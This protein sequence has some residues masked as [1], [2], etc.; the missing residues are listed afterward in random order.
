MVKKTQILKPDT[1]LKNYWNDNGQFADFFNAVLFG[2]EQVISP[3]DLEDVDTQESTILE[4]KEYAESIQAARDNI[5]ICKR[6]LTHGVEL[7]MLGIESQ[8]HIH[9][10]MPMRVMG[11]DYGAYKKQYDSNAVQYQTRKGL[12]ENEFLSRMKK[13]DKFIPVVTVVVYYGSIPWDGATTLYGMLNVSDRMKPFVNDYKML[14]VEARKN[15]LLFHNMNNV[16]F[17]NMIKIVL[18]SS[19]EKNAAKKKVIEYAAEHNV[20]KTVVMTV[21]GAAKC[22][23]DYHALSKKGEVGMYSLFDEI[24]KD[25][26]AE[27]KTEGRAEG[28]I[29]TG[30]DFG[31]SEEEILQ[32]LQDKLHLSLQKAQEYFELFGKQTV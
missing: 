24:A 9:Y 18:D 26:K 6:S 17:F 7:V 3:D 30:L 5:K 20:D 11:Y 32:R 31:L 27:G 19:M 10:A 4:H 25:C 14:L 12:D 1:V 29:E 16:D 22:A 8:E 13:T 28:I 23:I 21:A 2:G 15:D